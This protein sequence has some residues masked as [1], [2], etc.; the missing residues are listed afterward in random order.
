[1]FFK[2]EIKN[3]DTLDN[4]ANKY[5]TSKELIKNINNIY[6]DDMARIG[7]E[8]IIPSN[9]NI[10]FDKYLIKN[11]DTLYGIAKKTNSNAE[12]IANINGMELEDYIYAGQ[13]LLIPKKEYAYYLT[14]EGDTLNTTADMFNT[15]IANLL[16]NNTTIYLLPGQIMIN[17]K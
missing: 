4:I 2:Y 3:G 9:Q 10:Y 1:M 16:K 15:N 11:G 17:K 12:L 6:F 7:S 5:Q 14:K 13:Y 8:I